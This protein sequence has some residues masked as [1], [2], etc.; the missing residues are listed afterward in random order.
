MVPPALQGAPRGGVTHPRAPGPGCQGWRVPAQKGHKE[1]VQA[2]GRSPRSGSHPQNSL[3]L[4]TGRA[5]GSPKGNEPVGAGAPRSRPCWAC[6]RALVRSLGIHS[7]TPR[8]PRAHATS[9]ATREGGVLGTR[10]RPFSAAQGSS[11]H[12]QPRGAGGRRRKENR[13]RHPGSVPRKGVGLLPAG[14]PDRTHRR[15][16]RR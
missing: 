8:P 10:P 5:V 11:L 4:P 12:V 3:F 9:L 7:R 6:A 1:A 14:R 2:S 16:T 15:V 13:P